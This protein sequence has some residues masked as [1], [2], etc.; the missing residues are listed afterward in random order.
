MSGRSVVLVLVIVGFGVLTALALID[1]G[2]FGI[3]EPHFKSWGAAQVFVDLMIVAVLACV[4]M[5]D[6]ARARALSAW[7][8]VAITLIAGSFGPLLYLLVREWRSVAMRSAS[9]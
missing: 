3:I 9:V 4:W 1:V 2:Y 5:V 6:D 7:P 8:F